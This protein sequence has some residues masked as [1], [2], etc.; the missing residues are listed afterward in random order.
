MRGCLS[1]ATA[2]TLRASNVTVDAE[3]VSAY[4]EMFSTI[5]SDF[6]LFSRLYGLL[7]V[8]PEAVLPLLREMRIDDKHD[9]CTAVRRPF[10]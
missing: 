9:R 5:F 10:G 2:G 4:R 3:N 1:L 6:H 7:G 8:A